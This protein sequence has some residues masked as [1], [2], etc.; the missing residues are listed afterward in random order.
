MITT[1]TVMWC[2]SDKAIAVFL[3][4]RFHIVLLDTSCENH[5]NGYENTPW[6][7]QAAAPPRYLSTPPNENMKIRLCA[8]YSRNITK[9]VGCYLKKI[10]P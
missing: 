8:K 7:K 1:V 9:L 5:Q 4:Q 10:F 3:K 6:P 2:S